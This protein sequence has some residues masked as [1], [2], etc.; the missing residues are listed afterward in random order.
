LVRVVDFRASW[1]YPSVIPL[2][3]AIFLGIFMNLAPG[4]WSIG[5][6]VMTES[7]GNMV[8]TEFSGM[9]ITEFSGMVQ[10]TNGPVITESI[11]SPG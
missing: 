8:I 2:F 7:S 6:M 1:A 4:C 3:W 5:S 9:V 10:D 11:G